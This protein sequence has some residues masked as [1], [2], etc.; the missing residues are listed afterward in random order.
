MSK[1]LEK[2]SSQKR[3]VSVN[4]RNELQITTEL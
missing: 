3:Q 2:T 1:G 4:I